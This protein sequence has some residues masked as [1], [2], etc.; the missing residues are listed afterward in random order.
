MYDQYNIVNQC[1]KLLKKCDM[2]EI[3]RLRLEVH[4]IQVK[5]LLLNEAISRKVMNGFFGQHVFEGIR[6][7]IQGM[8]DGNCEDGSI[9]ELDA[10]IGFLLTAFGDHA[11]PDG[12][13]AQTSN[14]TLHHVF[15]VRSPYRD[16]EV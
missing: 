1:L 9:A 13:T 2:D 6:S 10:R 14:K 3:K 15:G 4:F 16:P 8:C 5:R 11:A 7:Q 12:F